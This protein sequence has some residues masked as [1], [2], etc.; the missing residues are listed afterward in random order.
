MSPHFYRD[1]LCRQTECMNTICCVFSPS[2][3]WIIFVGNVKEDSK[4]QNYY[5]CTENIAVYIR[6][7]FCLVTRLPD[8]PNSEI[9]IIIIIIIVNFIYVALS[10]TRL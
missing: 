8:C 5:L 2:L 4:Q 9:I 6:V 10:L 7:M 3:H 1:S